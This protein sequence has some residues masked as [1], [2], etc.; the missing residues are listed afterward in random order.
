MQTNQL[1]DY[2][3]CWRLSTIFV[4]VK[5]LAGPFGAGQSHHSDMATKHDARKHIAACSQDGSKA[6]LV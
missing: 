3:V 4:C 6:S 2:T 1:P 5:V